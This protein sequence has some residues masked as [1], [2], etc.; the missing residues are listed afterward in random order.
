MQKRKNI[1]ILKLVLFVLILISTSSAYTP[2]A[3]SLSLDLKDI[4]AYEQGKLFTLSNQNHRR[5]GI[6]TTGR[7][8]LLGCEYRL[9]YGNYLANNTGFGGL[10]SYGILGYSW[11]DFGYFKSGPLVGGGGKISVGLEFQL[12]IIHYPELN[13]TR[14][15]MA[16]GAGSF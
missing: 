4:I 13:N 3:W 11:Y 12:A 10:A 6:Y 14:F 9:G 7:L 1:P 15:S 8:G 2:N 16:I 5:S